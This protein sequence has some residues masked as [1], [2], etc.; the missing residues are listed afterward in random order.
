[1]DVPDLKTNLKDGA[2]SIKVG[3]DAGNWQAFVNINYGGE[4]AELKAGQLYNNPGQMGL[5]APVKSIRKF[6]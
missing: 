4:Q 3:A 1:M 2:K 5:S 6:T